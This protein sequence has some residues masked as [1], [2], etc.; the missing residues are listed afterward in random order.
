VHVLLSEPDTRKYYDTYTDFLISTFRFQVYC[1]SQL[2]NRIEDYLKWINVFEG[3]FQ[4]INGRTLVDRDVS[5]S[6]PYE[7]TERDG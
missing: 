6:G 5:F 4:G 7:P 1:T 3:G 2:G